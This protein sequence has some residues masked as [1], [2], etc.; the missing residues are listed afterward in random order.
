MRALIDHVERG[1]VSL[2]ARSRRRAVPKVCAALRRRDPFEDVGRGRSREVTAHDEAAL[3]A[4]RVGDAHY[5]QARTAVRGGPKLVM[6][7]WKRAGSEHVAVEA[8]VPLSHPRARLISPTP[9]SPAL[10][11]RAF[12]VCSSFGGFLL[13]RPFGQC[14]QGCSGAQAGDGLRSGGN[15]CDIYWGLGERREPSWIP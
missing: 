2:N 10:K 11:V 1:P 5:E 15:A 4:V 6:G 3:A 9:A 8:G 14:Q 13:L 12:I 7:Q